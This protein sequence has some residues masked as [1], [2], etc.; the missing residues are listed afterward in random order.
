VSSL[1]LVAATAFRLHEEGRLSKEELMCI[2]KR[3]INAVAL[4]NGYADTH[5]MPFPEENPL[6]MRMRSPR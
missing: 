3:C 2:V 4:D 5:G 1:Q 6:K